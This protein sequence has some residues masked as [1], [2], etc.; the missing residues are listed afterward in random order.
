MSIGKDVTRRVHSI[1]TN[2]IST[3]Y[4]DAN[5]AFALDKYQIALRF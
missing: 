3:D 1:V 5:L 2:L 4:Y